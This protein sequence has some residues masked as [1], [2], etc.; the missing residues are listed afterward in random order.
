MVQITSKQE[1]PFN[2]RSCSFILKKA[3]QDLAVM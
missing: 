2:E 1:T 3:T